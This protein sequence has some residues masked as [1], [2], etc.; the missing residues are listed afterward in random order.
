MNEETLLLWGFGLFAAAALLV[1]L[2]AFIPSGGLIGIVAGL[3]AIGGMVCFWRV[4]VTWGLASVLAMLVLAPAS[5]VFAL[6]VYPSTPIGRRM[7][8]GSDN[9]EAEIARRHREQDEQTRK[10]LLG[11]RGVALTDLRPVGTV[12]IENEK[13]EGLSES[14]QI[15]AGS[16]V[17]VTEVQGNR[18]KVRQTV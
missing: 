7:I 14:G 15:A 8:L 9:E 2:E 17:K 13:I 1:L 12:K 10:A 3:V 4:S 11:A 18:V 16:T 6:K 5:V